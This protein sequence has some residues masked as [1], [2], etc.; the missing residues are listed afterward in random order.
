MSR[1]GAVMAAAWVL[2]SAPAPAGGAL[3]QDVGIVLDV[4]PL[5]LGAR[6]AAREPVAPVF[7]RIYRALGDPGNPESVRRLEALYDSVAALAADRPDDLETRHL[8]AVVLGARSEVSTGRTRLQWAERMGVEAG[9]VLDRDPDHPGAMHLL[10]RLHAG[11]L[12]LGTVRRWLAKTLFG[13]ELLGSASW[14]VARAYLEAAERAEPCIPDHHFELAVLY[15][16]LGFPE[17][18]AAEA[19]HAI[20]VSLV[21]EAYAPVETKSVSLL[22]SLRPGGA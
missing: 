7:R 9:V 16:D 17:A 3:A 4:A 1:P 5:T 11:V 12:R 14:T 20:E 21:D 22:E 19:Q 18:A 6:C 13:G 10:G 8:L 15:A 2:L